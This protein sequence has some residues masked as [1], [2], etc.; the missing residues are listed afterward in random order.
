MPTAKSPLP[1]FTHEREMVLNRFALGFTAWFASFWLHPDPFISGAFLSY[2][3]VNTI[4][5]LALKRTWIPHAQIRLTA[6]LLDIAMGVSVIAWSP[7]TMSFIY[8]TF[9][10]MTLGNGFR[11][12]M[13]WLLIAAVLSATAFGWIVSTTAYWAD[14][15]VLG[16][17]LT[18]ALLVIPG[19]C[20]TLIR[21]LSDAKNA[22]EEANRAKSYFLASV[23]HELRTPLNAIIGY[24]NH[25]IQ[26]D[27]PRQ[28]HEMVDA[29]VR[30]GEHLLHLID[31]L[32]QIARND[33]GAPIVEM[34]PMQ[35]THVIAEI[36]DIMAVKAQEKGL[37]IYL[38]AEP[39]SDQTVIAPTDIVRN[40]LLNLIGNAIKFTESGSISI[41]IAV[42]NTPQKASMVLRISDTGIGIAREA[43]GRI[44]EPFQQADETVLNRFGGTG[45][46]LAICRQLLDQ[47]GGAISVESELGRG[48]TFTVSI[49]VSIEQT[50][51]TPAEGEA[52]VKILALGHFENSLLTKAQVAGNY[53]VRNIACSS[54][55]ELRD[56]VA[57]AKLSDFAIAMIDEILARQLASDDPVWQQ[58]ADSQVATVLVTTTSDIDLADVELRAAFATIIP[59]S[60]DFDQLRSAIRI[61]C[62]FAN[63]N[64][65]SIVKAQE[66]QQYTPRHILVADDNRTNRNILAAILEKA[67][68]RVSMVCDGDEALEA[69]EKGG[70]DILLLD[71]NMPRLNG[72][73]AARMWRQIEG[74][75]SRVPIV[76]VT[77]DATTETELRCLAA[78]MDKRLTKPVNAALLLQT[79]EEQCGST[80]TVTIPDRVD[81]PMAVVVELEQST[82]KANDPIDAGHIKYL[83]T[84]GDETFIREMMESFAAD[85]DESLQRFGDAVQQHDVE[86]F[87]FA[88][89][90]MKS[91][92]NNIGAKLLGAYCARL[93]KITEDE[94]ASQGA[95]H[96]QW[97]ADALQTSKDAL[98]QAPIQLPSP[99]YANSG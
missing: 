22:A 51:E 56:A 81:D 96:L 36:R 58:F 50:A 24:G 43:Q 6:I 82:D 69:L 99:R 39:F 38:H 87:R 13:K 20:S 97:I 27:M 53:H 48:T 92:S 76:G 40:I 42:E 21:K 9:L 28:Q 84:I 4:I 1:D 94:F 5:F 46:G 37:A 26:M 78:G 72:I 62:S 35:A 14:K 67:G 95:A 73:D 83:R 45:L 31:Q 44:F 11:F 12:G 23:S 10:W 2:L 41:H 16:Y 98:A 54:T 33:S 34:K 93:E 49:P 75:R 70:F 3:A 91:C 47:V 61:G 29:S 55:A 17:S 79:I 89:H 7:E 80:P 19:Y 25:L 85:A 32:I 88:A 8:P 18:V 30:A 63:P 86:S 57:Q 66:I 52:A 64:S 71:V 68:H 60:P 74:G 90:A 77:A 65:N 59:A 15:A